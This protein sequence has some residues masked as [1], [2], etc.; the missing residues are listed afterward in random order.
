MQIAG[1][2]SLREAIAKNASN[3]FN[4]SNARRSVKDK[5]DFS[6]SA[7]TAVQLREMAASDGKRVRDAL[8]SLSKDL[9]RSAEITGDLNKAQMAEIAETL[10]LAVEAAEFSGEMKASEKN[11]RL[12]EESKAGQS[13]AGQ[14]KLLKKQ[15]DEEKSLQIFDQKKAVEKAQ[16]EYVD[17]KNMLMK[18]AGE[19]VVV[20]RL[21]IVQESTKKNNEISAVKLEGFIQD[22]NKK[23]VVRTQQ[24]EEVGKKVNARR[25]DDLQIQ[26]DAAKLRADRLEESNKAVAKRAAIMEESNKRVDERKAMLLDAQNP[27]KSGDAKI[28]EIR[29]DEKFAVGLRGEQLRQK[30]KVADAQQGDVRKASNENAKIRDEDRAAFKEKVKIQNE[31]AAEEKLDTIRA[32]K[33]EADQK[34]VEKIEQKELDAAKDVEKLEAA[35]Q[36]AA[37]KVETRREQLKEGQNAAAEKRTERTKVPGAYRKMLDAKREDNEKKVLDMVREQ[38]MGTR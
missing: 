14:Q 27:A 37:K 11:Q 23:V 24:L 10:A 30:G 7:R 18:E 15:A 21:E 25:A 5:V 31:K 34:V 19:K 17:L 33:K 36:E 1:F 13:V 20:K 22:S 16:A 3:E 29:K 9:R 26:N 28:A 2:R 32:M 38:L 4:D 35:E 8:S 6:D 12:I